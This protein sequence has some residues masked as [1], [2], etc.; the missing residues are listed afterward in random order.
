MKA[1]FKLASLALVVFHFGLGISGRSTTGG[2]GGR[3]R[4]DNT[5]DLCVLFLHRFHLFNSIQLRL[6]CPFLNQQKITKYNST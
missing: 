3:R 5:A 2:S 6:Q 4:G 1:G